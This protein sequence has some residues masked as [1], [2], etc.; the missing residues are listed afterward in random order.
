[1]TCYLL[2]D[3]RTLSARIQQLVNDLRRYPRK[4]HLP[5][6]LQYMEMFDEPLGV[7]ERMSIWTLAMKVSDLFAVDGISVFSGTQLKYAHQMWV[8][9]EH[10]ESRKKV[11]SKQP[12]KIM[13]VEDALSKH[14]YL[15]KLIN[16]SISNM[17][18]PH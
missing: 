3:Q 13:V 8:R 1:M 11:N 16:N 12:T 9:R 10:H 17:R 4:N 6:P 5:P 18:G 7:H 14:L 2:V 15:S